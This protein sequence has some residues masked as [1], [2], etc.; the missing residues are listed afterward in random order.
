MADEIAARMRLA[1]D[2][3]GGSDSLELLATAFTQTGIGLVHK[4]VT[5]T[6]SEAALAIPSGTLGYAMF[7]CRAVATAGNYVNIK[8]ATSGTVIIKMNVGEAAMFRF[9]SGITAPYIHAVTGNCTVEYLILE[10]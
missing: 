5:A 10:A 8:T 7:V 1:V 9:G 2:N 6:T 3:A 4:T